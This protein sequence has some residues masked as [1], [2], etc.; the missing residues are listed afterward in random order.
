MI[1]VAIYQTSTPDVV[2]GIYPDPLADL[3]R[4]GQSAT[5][6]NRYTEKVHEGYSVSAVD[7][8]GHTYTV[9]RERQPALF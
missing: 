8:A 5:V 6:T 2:A 3:P 4:V 1:E 9:S 7:R